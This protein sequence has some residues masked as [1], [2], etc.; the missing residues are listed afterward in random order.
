MIEIDDALLDR[1]GL[2]DLPPDQK[3]PMK[4]HIY[5][6]LELRVGMRIASG[7]NDR[8]LTRF[9]EAMHSGD[10]ARALAVL[11]ELVPDYRDVVADEFEK[12]T[13]EIGAQARAILAA[14]R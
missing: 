1:L 8:E 9:E 14:S 3:Q 10:Q 2:G 12:L 11:Q 4:Q 7:F 5:E 6:T 13:A